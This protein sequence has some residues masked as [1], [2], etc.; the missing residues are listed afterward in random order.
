MSVN[1]VTDYA[2]TA[3]P[4]GSQLREE[5]PSA[6]VRAYKLNQ[7][8]LTQFMAGYVD[9]GTGFFEGQ[10]GD[11]FYKNLYKADEKESYFFPYFN[12]NFRSF[13]TNFANTFSNVSDRGGQATFADTV[14]SVAGQV[15]SFAGMVSEAANAFQGKPQGSYIETPKYYQYENTDDALQISFVLSNTIEDGDAEMNLEF[16]KNFTKLNKPERTSVVALSFPAI[17]KVQV[18][19]LRYIEWAYC[20]SIN[21]ELLGTRRKVGN[22][23]IPE[24]FRCTFSFKSLTLEPA[25]FIDKA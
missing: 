17:Y 21:F 9:L 3:I 22:N 7:A 14:Q 19:G 16:I 13:S 8:A 11:D 23:I 24:A 4:K 25:N 15:E 6:Y 10:G 1:I 20:E 2:W 5:A 12:D 18:Y